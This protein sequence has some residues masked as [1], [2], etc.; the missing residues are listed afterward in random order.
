MGLAEFVGSVFATAQRRLPWP[1]VHPL[2]LAT[3]AVAITVLYWDAW[4]TFIHQ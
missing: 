3:S 4:H 2:T 1:R